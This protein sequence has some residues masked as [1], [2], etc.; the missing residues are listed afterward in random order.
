MNLYDAEIVHEYSYRVKHSTLRRNETLHEIPASD[1]RAPA[2]HLDS[3][4]TGG[5]TMKKLLIATFCV[6]CHFR[7]R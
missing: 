6:F 4:R 1:A 5:T 7:A 3:D 2:A